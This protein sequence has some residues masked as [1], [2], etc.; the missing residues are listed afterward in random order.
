M[1]IEVERDARQLGNTRLT[2]QPLDE[3]GVGVRAL[4]RETD[5]PIDRQ[6]LDAVSGFARWLVR[7][8]RRVMTETDASCQDP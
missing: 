8:D 6:I 7:N 1:R 4:L 5:L 2:H 3:R